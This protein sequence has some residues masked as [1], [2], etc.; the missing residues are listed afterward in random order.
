MGAV[1]AKGS[2][3]RDLSP[4]EGGKISQ[5]TGQQ[6]SD[7]SPRN[8][9]VVLPY[10]LRDEDEALLLLRWINEL[11]GCKAHSIVLCHDPR[12]NQAT[13]KDVR[14]E[15]FKAFDKVYECPAQAEIDGWPQGANYLFRVVTAYL[16]DKPTKEFLWLE[17][18]AI[19]LRTGWLD[20]L[21][22]EYRGQNKPFMGDRVEVQIEGK[23]VPLHM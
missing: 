22:K 10:C 9:I 3:I 20:E 17:P 8:M 13:V 5:P 7:P 18:D 16:Q 1:R 15:A 4:A 21:E 14:V 2:R 6:G 11:G 12:C 19:P 23:D